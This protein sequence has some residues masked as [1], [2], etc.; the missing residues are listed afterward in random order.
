[1]SRSGRESSRKWAE[2]NSVPDL[3]H[4]LLP[5]STGMLFCLKELRDTVEWVYDCTVAYEGVP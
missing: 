3:E 1:M 5:R 4:A 2:K